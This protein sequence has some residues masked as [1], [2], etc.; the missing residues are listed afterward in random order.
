MKDALGDRMKALEGLEAGRMCLP[1][2]PVLARLDGRCFSNFTRDMQRPYDTNMTI[3]M[4]NT[5]K[6]LVTE[7]NACCGYSQSDEITLVWYEP[8]SRS[9]IFFNGCI[10]KMT[11]VLAA[12]ATVFFNDEI[13]NWPLGGTK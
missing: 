2:V 6:Y 8:D 4:Q 11:S 5:T 3:A 1:Q 7:T 12:L 9:E 10:Q 13:R